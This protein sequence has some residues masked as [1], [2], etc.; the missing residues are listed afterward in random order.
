MKITWLKDAKR[1]RLSFSYV[2]CNRGYLKGQLVG[3]LGCVTFGDVCSGD[4]RDIDG[5]FL[6]HQEV[7]PLVV[8]LE[9]RRM[10]L[11]SWS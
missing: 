7:V 5:G 4:G 6:R 8:D 2:S 3:G 9:N 10:P 1:I 11:E